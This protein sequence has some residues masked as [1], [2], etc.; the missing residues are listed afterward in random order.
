MRQFYVKER[1]KKGMVTDT[2]PDTIEKRLVPHER[3]LLK[4]IL[5]FNIKRVLNLKESLPL[6]LNESS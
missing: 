5:M 2:I 6:T 3:K 4:E 1:Q